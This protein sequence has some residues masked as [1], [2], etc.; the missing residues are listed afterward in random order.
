MLGD[1]NAITVTNQD[2]ILRNHSNPNPL[3]LDNDLVLSNR[4]KRNLEDL[5]ENLH[6][7][8]LIKI[9]ISRDLIICNGLMKWL[10]YNQMTC[11]HGLGSNVVDYVILNILVYNQ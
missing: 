11:I 6:D 10:K 5:I 9:F 1:F 7:I 3:W 4:Y 2:I 8:E